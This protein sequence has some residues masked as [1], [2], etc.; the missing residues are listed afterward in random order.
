M[1]FI[2][3]FHILIQNTFRI[4]I[5]YNMNHPNQLNLFE[6]FYNI[7]YIPSDDISD[8][9]RKLQSMMYTNKRNIIHNNTDHKK[10]DF[11]NDNT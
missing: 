8:F 5:G 2:S 1:T 10:K 4:L 3:Y 6:T 7:S 11:N 9:L